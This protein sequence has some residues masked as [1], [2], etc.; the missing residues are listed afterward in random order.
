M[1]KENKSSYLLLLSPRWWGCYNQ[2]D[3]GIPKWVCACVCVC[4][5]ICVCL[6]LC[7]CVCVSMWW[8]GCCDLSKGLGIPKGMWVRQRER[9]RE[10][11]CVKDV[12][13]C[14]HSKPLPTQRKPVPTVLPSRA[15]IRPA[16][17]SCLSLHTAL[18]HAY[19][20]AWLM[21]SLAH[22]G[23]V[24]FTCLTPRAQHRCL[25]QSRSLWA[26]K[27]TSVW[28]SSARR[29]RSSDGFKRRQIQLVT[30]S[31]EVDETGEQRAR[32]GWGP[33]LRTSPFQGQRSRGNLDEDIPEAV[34]APGAW[35]QKGQEKVQGTEGGQQSNTAGE[36]LKSAVYDPSLQCLLPIL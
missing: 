19:S 36:P 21:V 24:C 8:W 12:C 26:I 25:A 14:V 3:L 29:Y 5:C 16:S 15:P 4:L 7:V 2:Q 9:E 10:C 30:E 18:W 34:G 23:Q 22:T 33:A 13:V 35:C 6:W 32:E 28:Q 1:D 20:L 17:H 31:K 11:V 27:Q